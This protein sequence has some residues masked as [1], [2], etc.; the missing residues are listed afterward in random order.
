MQGVG[1][2]LC[3]LVLVTVTHL[4]GDDYDLQWRIALMLGAVPMVIAF[5][6]R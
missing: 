2:L 4:L 3:A 1:T 6:F 5:Y